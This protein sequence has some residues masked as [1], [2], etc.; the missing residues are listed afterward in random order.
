MRKK[1]MLK[2]KNLK[3]RESLESISAYYYKHRLY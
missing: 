1:C 2:D 3:L